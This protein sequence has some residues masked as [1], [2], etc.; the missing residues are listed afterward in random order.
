[1]NPRDELLADILGDLMK[2]QAKYYMT[3]EMLK[4]DRRAVAIAALKCGL[5]FSDWF[6]WTANGQRFCAPCYFRWHP[7]KM[8]YLNMNKVL[9][10]EALP[11]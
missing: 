8:R 7:H 1:M 3:A 10:M 11:E 9:I 6:T 2:M 4:D 5:P